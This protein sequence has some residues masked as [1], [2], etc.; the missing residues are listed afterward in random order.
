MKNEHETVV[1]KLDK[2][3]EKTSGEKMQE[4]YKSA[5][6]KIDK[7]LKQLEEEEKKYGKRKLKVCA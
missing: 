5:I 4:E 7:L 1:K 6:K 3:L 2:L